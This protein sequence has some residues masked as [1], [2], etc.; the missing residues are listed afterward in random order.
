[1]HSFLSRRGFFCFFPPHLEIHVSQV[2]FKPWSTSQLVHRG[3]FGCIVFVLHS[4]KFL[5]KEAWSFSPCPTHRVRPLRP[6]GGHPAAGRPVHRRHQRS[7]RARGPVQAFVTKGI[8]EEFVTGH[9]SLVFIANKYLVRTRQSTPFKSETQKI[10]SAKI[11]SPHGRHRM[12]R[13]LTPWLDPESGK[14]THVVPNISL[15]LSNGLVLRDFFLSFFNPWF[16]DQFPLY[17]RSLLIL[18][19][20]LRNLD[21][22]L[23]QRKYHPTKKIVGHFCWPSLLYKSSFFCPNSISSRINHQT[24]FFFCKGLG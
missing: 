21:V 7:R 9:N 2:L 24:D 8:C 10:L 14:Y 17:F 19:T 12:R 13:K 1:M 3:T 5:S 11:R 23:I 6:C 20:V 15:R 18:E 4:N 16:I 22:T